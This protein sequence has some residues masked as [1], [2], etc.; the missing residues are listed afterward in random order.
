V[1]TAAKPRLRALSRFHAIDLA[2][3]I[4]LWGVL[5]PCRLL[6]Q[7]DVVPLDAARLA[8]TERLPSFYPGNWTYYD[9]VVLFDLAGSPAAYAIIF[10]KQA[11]TPPTPDH[12]RLELEARASEVARLQADILD[13][14]R[15]RV[16]APERATAHLAS[17]RARLESE[18]VA[19]AGYDTFVTVIT[20]ARESQPL[21][22]RAH[23]GLPE[24]V[25]KRYDAQRLAARARSGGTW[26]VVRPLYLGMFD[27]AFEV[28]MEGS[29][30]AQGATDIPSGQRV[31][32]ELGTS[33]VATVA[34]VAQRK[35]AAVSSAMTPP[36]TAEEAKQRDA[37]V[38]RW[39]AY[40]ARVRDTARKTDASGR[41]PTAVS[42]ESGTKDPSTRRDDQ[43]IA[44]Y[45]L[46]LDL[47]TGE[48]TIVSSGSQQS[49]PG[50]KPEIPGGAA[51]PA[52]EKPPLGTP[53]PRLGTI[54]E[55]GVKTATTASAI[56]LARGPI[57][58][59][60][61]I[62]SGKGDSY[63]VYGDIFDWAPGTDADAD[64]YYETY[65]FYIGIDGDAS[66]GPATVYGRMICT[67]TSQA[68]WSADPWT[69]EGLD[70]D[71]VYFNF[72][73]DDFP[74]VS[75][76]TS[77][78]F[79]VEI[80]NA[81]KTTAL[82][83]DTSVG[84]EPI[85][86]DYIG[87]TTYAVFGDIFD[88][89]PGTDADVDGY[90]ETY[91]FNI[92]I[93]GDASPG[94]VTVY[95]KVICTTTGQTWWSA[96]SWAIQ[97]TATDYVYLDFTQDDFPSVSGNTSL[98][99]TVEI[100]DASKTTVLA[101][102][103]S[104]GGEPILADGEGSEQRNEIPGASDSPSS[105]PTYRNNP[106]L[107]GLSYSG[108]ICWATA[109]ADILAYW[110]RNAYAGVTYWNLVNHGIAPLLQD[111][112][113]TAPGHDQADVRDLIVDLADRYYDGSQAEDVIIEAVAN[114]ERGLG[115]N[116]TYQG[117]V[118]TLPGK[119]AF[120]STVAA[121][122]DAGRP[123][124]LGSFGSYFGGPHEIPV[125]GYL[126]DSGGDAF[127]IHRNTGGTTSEY[128]NPYDSSWGAMDLDT[129]VPGGTPSDQYENLD[130]QDDDQ[131][132]H[133]KSIDPTDVYGF[134]QTHNFVAG[135]S[136]IGNDTE[137]WVKFD[138]AVGQ[139]YTIQTEHLG[140]SCD[141]TLLLDDGLVN[142]ADDNSGPEPSASKIVYNA[143]SNTT[144]Y[145]RIKESGGHVGPDTNYDISVTSMA[146]P[147]GPAAFSKTDPG[148]GAT[149]QPTNPTLTWSTSTGAT[150]YEY[151]VDTTNNGICD[152]GS[153]TSTGTTPS[154]GL[155][156]L[157]HGRIYYWQVRARNATGTTDANTGTWWGFATLQAATRSD[158]DGDL[159]A[160]PAVYRP[161]TGTWFS[162]DSST[163]NT[164]FSAR[165]WG[166]QAQGDVPVLGDFDGDG[167]IDPTVFRPTTGT[168]FILMS[169][170]D[171]TDWT[172]FGWGT[173]T[174]T[175]VPGDYDGDAIADAAVYRPSTGE[176]F[177]R[178]SS[179][180]GQW[181][182]TFGGEVGDLPLP[183]DYDG[184]GITDIAV[185]RPAS[186]TWFV[187]TS[188]SGFVDWT[189]QGWGVQAEGDQPTPGDYDGDGKTDL[190]VFRPATG[191]WFV[192]ESH[193]DFT[194]WTW[195]G[196]GLAT[197]VP[198]PADYDGDGKTDLAVYRPST[199]E[200][201]IRPSTGATPWSAVFGAPG[202]V[203]L[204]AIR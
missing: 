83:T 167:T 151:C 12:L 150:S 168:W 195:S 146:I 202:D 71:Y 78:D 137:D 21:V 139:R 119:E 63:S 7:P 171:Y 11:A 46:R 68:W 185:Y 161:D 187:L 112:L 204:P 125:I 102:D 58:L 34:D 142:M 89:A 81:S 165:G 22:L 133:A 80:W 25:Y 82:A 17:L 129:I 93:D 190:A 45:R 131:M 172:W 60:S 203:P 108:G 10:S 20:G 116:A 117:P 170:A 48:T 113:P 127:Y 136:G 181:S 1:I 54:Q 100:W 199:G 37:N 50:L 192:L 32:V 61:A 41:V 193:A 140:S 109:V 143:T 104:V 92:G 114:T 13:A 121:E 196:W 166:V 110:D 15:Q 94:P 27:E 180:A 103:T 87:T 155:S 29:V 31:V 194:T 130:G 69:I 191:T 189:F 44:S 105:V 128:V 179:G 149:G 72:T 98:D 62:P 47:R 120:F 174:D 57:E 157:S 24:A 88:W 163:G 52:V 85:M 75:G 79:T 148:N 16:T 106:S 99:F 43:P 124:A 188:S 64:G 162:L 2:L 91:S 55:V 159:L 186:G 51:T 8:A 153:W 164:T 183:Y 3:V 144:V 56:R 84:G 74:S 18:E 201:Y 70:Y 42:P 115:F 134:R 49:V 118:T 176:W 169:S 178:P 23:M 40:E 158:F 76:N 95:G 30:A 160:D 145:I 197:D 35:N 5:L 147:P 9:D 175:L 111:V 184:D 14:T 65:S 107:W 36:A 6:A 73:Q 28:A 182:V 126:V 141:T 86:A 53:R 96:S 198:V 156:G 97:G 173:S 59:K 101:T 77:L 152:S 66:P 67:T 154:A 38:A 39:R 33:T 90:Y 200:W 135:V 132:S 123:V 19:R 177:I 4:L 122:I 26:R 138:V